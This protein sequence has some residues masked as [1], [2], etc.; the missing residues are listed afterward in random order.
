M[1]AEPGKTTGEARTY[2]IVE[3]T[4]LVAR[5]LLEAVLE[6]DGSA[7]VSVCQSAE[8]ARRYLET[9]EAPD[10]ICLGIGGDRLRQSGL[11][12]LI[13]SGPFGL[14]ALEGV[15]KDGLQIAR[16]HAR[17]PRPFVTEMV[18]SALAEV[19]RRPAAQRL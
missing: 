16:P 3:R 19:T 9:R 11:L 8:D 15:M 6:W 4:V 5:D 1:D 14:V 13:E 18:H 12:P 2:L 7:R 17:L 10:V